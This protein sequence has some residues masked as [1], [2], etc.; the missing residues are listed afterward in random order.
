TTT[1]ATLSGTNV[2]GAFSVSGGQASHLLLE[3]GG[4]LLVLAGDTAISTTVNAG[5]T[6]AINSGGILDGTT[7]L[8]DGAMLTDLGRQQGAS[9]INRGILK[10]SQ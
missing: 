1:R 10:F 3:N 8:T 5:G 4:Q 7:T 9:V 6:L 2:L